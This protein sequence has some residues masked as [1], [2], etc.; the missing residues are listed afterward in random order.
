MTWSRSGDINQTGK[1]ENRVVYNNNK[2][3]CIIRQLEVCTYPHSARVGLAVIL[4]GQQV[5]ETFLNQLPRFDGPPVNVSQKKLRAGIEN[6]N[7]EVLK[8]FLLILHKTDRLD[9]RTMK[10][11]STALK[12]SLPREL[13]DIIQLADNGKTDEAL[14]MASASIDPDASLDAGSHYDQKG[15]HE[16]AIH[17]YR[18]WIAS[19]KEQELAEKISALARENQALK[20]ENAKLKSL[21]P[22]HEANMRHMSNTTSLFRRL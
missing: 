4:S 3:N 13:D 11:L 2:T 7:R 18:Q 10:E 20:A 14:T 17:F 19:G 6:D 15:D 12:I 1:D 16:K 8:E 22:D 5:L 21:P 9:S